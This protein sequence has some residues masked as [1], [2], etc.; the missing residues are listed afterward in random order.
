MSAGNGKSIKATAPDPNQ[1]HPM[2]PQRSWVWTLNNPS[3]EEADR[4][5]LSL[6]DA[7]SLCD[8]FRYIVVGMEV[9]GETDTMHLQGFVELTAPMRMRAVQSALAPDRPQQVH[10]EPRRGTREQARN[11]IANDDKEGSMGWVE[12]GEWR[13]GGQGTRSDL[14]ACKALL[15]NGSSMLD[16]AEEH[17]E[18]WCRH[19]QAFARYLFLKNQQASPQWRILTTTILWGATGSGKSRAAYAHPDSKFVI[20]QPESNGGIWW[21]GYSGEKVLIIDEFT[22]WISLTK[23]LS[24]LDGYPLRLPTKGGHTWAQWTE[25][26]LTSNLCP[27]DWYKRET[28][29]RHPG[30]LERRVTYVRYFDGSSER[31]VS[32]RFPTVGN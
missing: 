3:E 6:S 20:T 7:T 30:A 12:A 21:D 23:L 5:F 32:F 16:V 2:N 13:Q 4:L 18:P 28:M 10:M 22:G 11:Y 27:M 25:V 31:N 1:A 9:G 8:Q 19:H 17:F 29:D 15:D 24:I 26:I 14:L